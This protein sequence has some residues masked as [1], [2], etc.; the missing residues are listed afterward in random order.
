[1]GDVGILKKERT[2]N[3]ITNT[4][5]A[6]SATLPPE[7]PRDKDRGRLGGPTITSRRT[8]R[9]IRERLLRK[10]VSNQNLPALSQGGEAKVVNDTT[11]KTKLLVVANRLPVT[12]TR[13]KDGNWDLQSSAGGLVSALM[14]VTTSTTTWIG[15]PGIWVPPGKDRNTLT[16]M[17]AKRNFVPV[18]MEPQLADS[19]YNGFCNSVLWQLFHYVPLNMDT[20]LSESQMV[21]HQ[22][23]AY[24]LANMEFARIV[25]EIYMR[26]PDQVIWV[27]DYHLML[28]PQM[29]KKAHANMRVGFFLHTPFPSSEIYRTL[30]VRTEV[31]EAM[32]KADLIGFHTYDY[33]RHFVSACTRIL[34]LEG[35]PEGVEEKDGRLT[36][37]A[38]FPIGIDPTR[39]EL[40]LELPEVKGH[41]KS[42]L[43][44]YQGRKVMLGV[45]RLD[46]IK[47]IPQ[48]LLAFEKFLEENPELGSKTLLVQIAVPSRTDV[49]EYQ[50]LR[51]MVHE[52]VGRIN[53]KFGT[54]THNPICHLDKQLGFHELCALYA[55]T[56]V[57]LVT[58]LRDGMNLVSY[59]YVACQND[60]KGVLVLSEFAGAAQS[61]GAGA[62]L[63]NPWNIKELADAIRDAVNMEQTDRMR[64]HQVNYQHIKN[65]TSQ[66]WA[67]TFINE[68][69][70]THVE[71]EERMRHVPPKLDLAAVVRDFANSGKRLLVLGTNSTLLMSP[72]EAQN[73]SQRNQKLLE[74]RIVPN[75]KNM[76]ALEVIA[77][78]PNTMVVIFSGSD[79]SRLQEYYGDLPVWL[80]AENGT[81]VRGPYPGDEW[82]LQVELAP[83]LT[84]MESV[85][86]VLEYYC[87][88]TPCSYVERRDTSLVWNYAYADTEYARLQARDLLQ[89]MWTGPISNAPVDIVQGH[90]SVEVR[91]VGTSKGVSMQR[92][93]RLKAQRDG[94]E[95]VKFDFVFV[96]GHFLGRDENI[97]TYFQGHNI[98]VTGDSDFSR[99]T[100]YRD[101]HNL[102]QSFDVDRQR[103]PM[104]RP[105]D[106]GLALIAEGGPISALNQFLSRSDT[107]STT[108]SEI[109]RTLQATIL[110]Q[111]PPKHLYTVTVN[112]T[113]SQAEAS[114][115]GSHRMTELLLMLASFIDPEV[116][117]SED[118]AVSARRRSQSLPHALS[119]R[120]WRSQSPQENE[121][122]GTLHSS[123]LGNEGLLCSSDPDS[124]P[125]KNSMLRGSSDL[126]ASEE[127]HD[128][129]TYSPREA[130]LLG[131][132]SRGTAPES[133]SRRSLFQTR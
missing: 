45:D 132:M 102:R 77:S 61:L 94:P 92:V 28:L 110:P 108:S 16:Q 55:V 43:Q 124:L 116:E 67:D 72:E 69:N 117:I 49:P 4:L 75:W 19:H 50:R 57:L 107:T 65:H 111:W 84:W 2:E 40:A 95:S 80:A 7:K 44:R 105:L 93:L 87:E 68:L 3:Y 113:R 48:K 53:G 38:A 90:R 114:L 10:S 120:P 125:L 1:M 66:T 78:D 121:F 27:Q 8:E 12:P 123:L 89:H 46:M 9:L 130:A 33:A 62:I 21:F 76:R 36:R 129:Q 100:S 59:E 79:K 37:V 52:I 133:L 24:K 103:P 104:G 83:D 14:G 34:G 119:E 91:P 56:D 106:Q 85:N 13:D 20:K 15:W 81:F 26:D 101:H 58:S 115:D 11:A 64:R 32:L 63:I 73:Q 30:P 122:R 98:N 126:D 23:E 22:W 17:L 112:R 131:D 5:R 74:L 118:Q 18:Y 97:F 54:L 39:F 35:N 31:L 96:A 51:S 82:E 99:T 42:L 47:G 60:N 86:S 88:R 71:A 41:V 29:L 6:Q 127:Y 109:N 25:I 70:D 128:P